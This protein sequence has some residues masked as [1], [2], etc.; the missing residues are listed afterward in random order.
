M[1]AVRVDPELVQQPAQL[2][3]TRYLSYGRAFAIPHP[4]L[5]P[6]L[7]HHLV[8]QPPPVHAAPGAVHD[9]RV[10][11][12]PATA[13]KRPGSSRIKPARCVWLAAEIIERICDPAS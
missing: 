3:G 12:P 11:L 8:D 7:V 6:G 9:H 2:G 4:V 10:H 5:H 1:Q 13:T